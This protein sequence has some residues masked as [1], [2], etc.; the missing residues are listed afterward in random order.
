MQEMSHRKW[1]LNVKF[2]CGGQLS[3]LF[4]SLFSMNVEA[5]NLFLVIVKIKVNSN[6]IINFYRCIFV[7]LSFKIVI[8]SIVMMIVT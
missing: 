4:S 1:Y 2:T 6:L 5:V 8:L 7:E 3:F